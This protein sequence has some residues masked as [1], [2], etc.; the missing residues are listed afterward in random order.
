[1]NKIIKPLILF[2][3]AAAALPTYAHDLTKDEVQSLQVRA[4]QKVD[5]FT[6]LLQKIVNDSI[7]KEMRTQIKESTL[8][9]FAGNGRTYT[10]VNAYGET[11]RR[12]PV[13]MEITSLNKAPRKSRMTIYLDNQLKN[14]HRYRHVSISTADVVR[15]GAI[16]KVGNGQY[17]CTAYFCQKYISYDGEGNI[18]YGDITE[19]SVVMHITQRDIPGQGK[20]FE[21]RLGDISAGETR[22]IK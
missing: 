14:I 9:L 8:A 3:I 5:E 19:K 16:H 11:E 13:M 18:V 17:T 6:R 15:V 4:K 1:M 2:L 22:R 20:V 21:V 7:S 12:G 10:V